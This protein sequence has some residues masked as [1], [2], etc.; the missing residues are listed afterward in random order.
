MTL[1]SP[2]PAPTEAPAPARTPRRDGRSFGT[3]FVGSLLEAWSELRIH[4]TRVLLSLIGVAIAVCALTSVVGIGGVAQQAQIEQLE[5]GSGRPATLYIGAPY[6]PA[7]GRTAQTDE[8]MTV[9][10]EVMDRYGI[11]Y[12]TRSGWATRG[13]QL[14]G[15]VQQV[16]FQVVD[17]PYGEMHRIELADGRWFTPEDADRLAPLLVVNEAFMASIGSPDLAQHPSVVL[18]GQQDTTAVIAGVVPS[19]PFDDYPRGFILTE[20]NDALGALDP[21][22]G[23]GPPQVEAWIPPENADALTELVR[24]DITGSMGEGWQIDIN[25]Q[26]YLAWGSGDPLEPIRIGLTGVAVLI[27]LL[28]ALGLVNISL[29]TVRQRIREIGIR[30][31]FGATAGR[32]FFA[33]MMESVVATVVAGAVGVAAAVLIVRS[34]W[35]QGLVAPGLQDVPPFPVDAALIGLGAATVV[36]A[37]AGLLPALVAVRVKVIDAIRY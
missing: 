28:G 30:R 37:L 11:G 24:R 14:P 32:V 33:V 3:G 25:R 19:G 9:V 31:S 22:F 27:L 12:W 21:A 15:G 13:V 35:V 2:T 4:R 29:V 17:A 36:G 23:F 20:A 7:N 8:F 5:R 16:E 18:Q 10:G 1:E 26:D 34:D 6:D